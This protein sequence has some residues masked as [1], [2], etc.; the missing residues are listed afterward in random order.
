MVKPL[1]VAEI[2][3]GDKTLKQKIRS[4][5]DLERAVGQGLPKEALGNTTRYVF[6]RGALATSFAARIVP[7]A[8]YK[9]RKKSL[10]PA[11]SE[12][13]E[14]VARVVATAAYVW[15]DREKAIRFL[16]SP[17]P[18]LEGRRPIDAAISDLGARR[19]EET[20]MHLQ[21]GLPV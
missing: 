9:R 17:H 8:T 3:G 12:K 10:A 16:L 4:A 18:L 21:H 7:P 1:A 2:L 5:S 6:G 13:L 14:R 19:V 20:L 15:G 11:E